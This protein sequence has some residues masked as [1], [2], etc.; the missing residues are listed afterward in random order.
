MVRFIVLSAVTL[1]AACAVAGDPSLPSGDVRQRMTVADLTAPVQR[2]VGPINN[3]FYMPLGKSGPARHDFAGVLTFPETEMDASAGPLVFFKRPRML[4]FPGFKAAFFRHGDHLVPARRDIIRVKGSGSVW[5]VILQP[6]RV[7]SEAT[8]GEW[9][10]ASFPFVLTDRFLNDTYNGIA[11]FLFDGRQV[12]QLAFQ[13]TQETAYAHGQLDFSGRI[14]VT[15]VAGPLPDQ[16][17]RAAGFDTELADRMTIEP[18]S[19]LLKTH[20]SGDLIQLNSAYEPP[21]VTTSAVLV[22]DVLYAWPCITRYGFYPY[23]REM[24]HGV[25]SI[26]KTLGAAVALFRLAAK[27][28]DEVMGEKIVDYVDVNAPHDGW[29]AVSFADILNMATG[30]GDEAPHRLPLVTTADEQ[31]PKSVPFYTTHS[32]ASKLAVAFSYNNYPWGPGEVFRYNTLHTFVLAAA[33]DGFL[34]KKEGPAAHLW[35]M[36]LKEVLR[37]I[38]VH[39]APL[40]HTRDVRGG[41]GIPILGFGYYPTL[42]DTAKIVRLLQNSGRHDGTQILSPALVREALQ[43]D[44]LKGLPI[45]S[46]NTAGDEWRYHMSLW[47]R[48]WR[49]TDDCLVPLP[50][51]SGRGGSQI[52]VMPNGISV[53]RFTDAEIYDNWT[54]F[55]AGAAVRPVCP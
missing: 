16:K 26:T 46:K 22:D 34:K 52:A 48:P 5:E 6:G 19:G 27:Y 10:R 44:G 3:A 14:P 13:V 55:T 30:I 11:M 1:L 4:V 2:V 8:D 24:R 29:D 35:D 45:G 50:Y 33:M 51:M 21:S 18:W 53:F 42:E 31:K 49:P 25:Y 32:A 23:C 47:V 38:G 41:P 28:G 7:W 9:S 15:F 43:R 40:R 17:A 36:V 37:P 12:S 54:L 39:H 20:L